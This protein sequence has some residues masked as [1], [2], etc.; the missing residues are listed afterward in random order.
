MGLPRG[1]LNGK[2]AQNP[3]DNYLQISLALNAFAGENAM[4][5]YELVVALDTS[6]ARVVELEEMLKHK[7]TILLMSSKE[8]SVQQRIFTKK[9]WKKYCKFRL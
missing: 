6:Q 9:R 3:K 5:V 8:K 1:P 7:E 4:S 2:Q